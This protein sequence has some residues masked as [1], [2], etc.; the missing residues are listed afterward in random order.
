MGTVVYLND[1]PIAFSSV[2]QKQVMLSGTEAELATEV[3]MVKDMMYVYHI[4]LSMGLHV[5]LPMIAELDNS[6]ARDLAISCGVG[7]RTRDIDVQMFY[8]QQVPPGRGT[9][10]CHPCS[11]QGSQSLICT[12][13]LHHN[14]F[15]GP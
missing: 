14:P 13:D 15:T 11:H 6:W 2:T 10:V 12:R 3:T 7:G 8:L 4:I 1:A 9:L 5:L